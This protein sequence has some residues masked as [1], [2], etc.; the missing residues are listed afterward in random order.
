[1]AAIAARRRF[2]RRAAT[3]PPAGARAA[4]ALAALAWIAASVY[5][6]SP[7]SSRASRIGELWGSG[8]NR[9]CGTGADGNTDRSY[10]CVGGQLGVG[11]TV[12]RADFAAAQWPASAG[13]LPVVTARVS[14]GQLHTLILRDDGT[15]HATG[16]NRYGQLGLGHT[17]M[18]TV[19]EPMPIGAVTTVEAGFGYSIML[20]S[21]GVL[22]ACG[23]NDLHQL[24]LG[25]DNDRAAPTQIDV[26]P[27]MGLSSPMVTVSAGEN[28]V[29]AVN[30]VGEVFAW[31]S[32]ANG[33]LGLGDRLSSERPAPVGVAA[34]LN[35]LGM[36]LVGADGKVQTVAAGRH[37]SVIIYRSGAASAC[38]LNGHGQLGMNGLSAR[39]TFE[40]CQV[41]TTVAKVALGQMHTLFLLSDGSVRACGG[42][43]EGQLGFES[44]GSVMVPLAVNTLQHVVQIAAAGDFSLAVLEDGS[45]WAMGDNNKGQLGVL[46]VSSGYM[47][48]RVGKVGYGVSDVATGFDFVHVIKGACHADG[49][50]PSRADD[51]W[52]HGSLC[53][54]SPCLPGRYAGAASQTGRTQCRPGSVGDLADC[55]P[56]SIGRYTDIDGSIAESDCLACAAGKYSTAEGSGLCIDCESGRYTKATRNTVGCDQCAMGRYTQTVGAATFDECV[57]C[58]VGSIAAVGNSTCDLCQAGLFGA[59]AD[60]LSVDLRCSL[61]D[62]GDYS[63]G[64]QFPN[65]HPT[66]TTQEAT[67]SECE[68]DSEWVGTFQITNT[69]YPAGCQNDTCASHPVVFSEQVI[70]ADMNT[71]T[72][73]LD[74]FT[75]P[76][77]AF[78]GSGLPPLSPICERITRTALSGRGVL[79]SGNLTHTQTLQQHCNGVTGTSAA[80]NGAATFAVG[81][82]PVACG[83]SSGCGRS[84]SGGTILRDLWCDTVRLTFQSEVLFCSP[85]NWICPLN[86]N[87]YCDTNALSSIE[88]K[89]RS[90]SGAV[91][92]RVDLIDNQG[93]QT[94]RSP[95]TFAVPGGQ[96]WVTHSL[97]F[98]QK[99]ETLYREGVD[100][101]RITGLILYILDGSTYTSFQ[102]EMSV[103]SVHSANGSPLHETAV[104][105]QGWGLHPGVDR[106]VP[107]TGCLPCSIG[108]YLDTR[109]AVGDLGNCLPCRTGMFSNP[110]SAQCAP[111]PT[112]TYLVGLACVDCSPG[113]YSGVLGAIHSYVCSPCAVGRYTTSSGTSACTHCALGKYSERSGSMTSSDC[114]N[115]P[116]GKH[117]NSTEQGDYT[118][119]N[120]CPGGRVSL[121]GAAVCELCPVGKGLPS[122][123]HFGDLNLDCDSCDPGKYSTVETQRFAATWN[124]EMGLLEQAPN[125]EFRVCSDCPAGRWHDATGASH[126]IACDGGRFSSDPG[127]T[128]HLACRECDLGKVSGMGDE[129]CAGCQHGKTFI[130]I[131]QECTGCPVGTDSAFESECSACDRPKLCLGNGTCEDGYKGR[132]CTNCDDGHFQYHK[133]CY[134]CPPNSFITLAFG[135]GLFLLF[136][137]VMI[138]LG[139][140]SGN[141]AMGGVVAPAALGVA[142]LQVSLKVFEIDFNLPDFVLDV[143]KWL[144]NLIT[145]DF[146]G[147]ATPECQWPISDP[148]LL[149]LFRV[150]E[151]TALLPLTCVTILVLSLTWVM[152]VNFDNDRP[153]P[154][155]SIVT[156]FSL[157]Y[158]AMIS[159][160]LHTLNCGDITGSGELRLED[161]PDVRCQGP[162]DEVVQDLHRAQVY[163]MVGEGFCLS[164]RTVG[165]F[166]THLLEASD[167]DSLQVLVYVE[168]NGRVRDGL[169]TESIC[170]DSCTAHMNCA[171][172]SYTD[173][174]AAPADREAAGRCFL[175]GPYLD[176]DL[177]PWNS[178]ETATDEWRAY[179]KGKPN[180]KVVIE[181]TTVAACDDTIIRGCCQVSDGMQ[182]SGNCQQMCCEPLEADDGEQWSLILAQKAGEKEEDGVRACPDGRSVHGLSHGTSHDDCRA[183]STVCKTK[184]TH[185]SYYWIIASLGV[186]ILVVCGIVL[187]VLIFQKLRRADRQNQFVMKRYGWLYHRFEER[188]WFYEF[189]VMGQKAVIIAIATFLGRPDKAW[190]A[191]GAMLGCIFLMLAM[192][193]RVQPWVEREDDPT[194]K[195]CCGKCLSTRLTL[196]RLEEAGICCQLLTVIPCGY[197]IGVD[198]TTSST[199]I[200]LGVWILASQGMFVLAVI[201]VQY[202]KIKQKDSL[203]HKYMARTMNKIDGRPETEQYRQTRELEAEAVQ[204][205]VTTD[206]PAHVDQPVNPYLDLHDID[207]SHTPVGRPKPSRRSRIVAA[208]EG[209]HEDQTPHPESSTRQFS[210]P[211]RAPLVDTVEIRDARGRTRYIEPPQGW[212]DWDDQTKALYQNLQVLI[213]GKVDELD[214]ARAYGRSTEHLESELA[215]LMTITEQLSDGSLQRVSPQDQE[216]H[217][218]GAGEDEGMT[219]D[220]E[221]HNATDGGMMDSRFAPGFTDGTAERSG[222][223]GMAVRPRIV[224]DAVEDDGDE[225]RRGGAYRSPPSS[226]L[227]LVSV[228]LDPADLM[229]MSD[230]WVGDDDIRAIAAVAGD[231]SDSDDSYE[232]RAE[233]RRRLSAARTE[234]ASDSD[235]GDDAVE[236]STDEEQDERD[237]Q[238]AF[239]IAQRR[240]A[241]TFEAERPRKEEAE[242][243]DDA[244]AFEGSQEQGSDEDWLGSDEDMI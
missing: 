186:S 48:M 54:C 185:E 209:N 181:T 56:C 173:L 205:I 219:D 210:V 218:D 106:V 187:P 102:G 62:F 207:R 110:G 111:C 25:D 42:N 213:D 237:I 128:T 180:A 4:A 44:A 191:W 58:P 196:N 168:V 38:G 43:Q 105:G 114:V 88:I 157:M 227:R 32:N 53:A 222:V 99:F 129:G 174:V 125:I 20:Q 148:E 35:D 243:S 220:P 52:N 138:R 150:S 232:D 178:R 223:V 117:K 201:L 68:D 12:N 164:T 136:A 188:A 165:R 46:G 40:P 163:D 130:A 208:S 36:D 50:F 51:I 224:L 30:A 76:C 141:Q 171:A 135:V 167:S 1:M 231:S 132:W 198:D 112:G 7:A 79:G 137:L 179:T 16:N 156:A 21:D 176:A 144:S 23:Q 158:V 13:V 97:D 145:L 159:T 107:E 27:V 161:K 66:G 121:D 162:W 149:Y 199:A 234:A 177:N 212:V 216:P 84:A 60:V 11:D 87:C 113:Q 238:A 134:E 172:Y 10:A 189:V 75:G 235:S 153:N 28:H 127:R 192:Q 80:Q 26:P 2:S 100:A 228:D 229:V 175:H 233:L 94:S 169:L 230:D 74:V 82:C 195:L 33:A 17:L 122:Y 89:I 24:G 146:V 92:V 41:P 184:R 63:T 67:F 22:W 203:L 90:L 64:S 108:K 78:Q 204:G 18:V 29:L 200:V 190:T 101:R 59:S 6:Q 124:G 39:R 98:I 120:S 69:I 131:D 152:A 155:N 91:N 133:H 214:E 55:A 45:L 211:G 154:I 151:M 239:R 96:E 118:S 109:G 123:E 70:C 73:C 116:G 72:C 226:P 126:C 160:G 86:D 61:D 217:D 170:Q 3:M 215:R 57:S 19:P 93:K 140:V 14:G 240:V 115:C 9:F 71:L 77:V 197:F 225:P 15:V 5:A 85:N 182:A 194:V 119:C 244:A 202:T 103:A 147:F 183:P 236:A 95:L 83:R 31:G 34:P 139:K 242:S 65:F 241:P 104:W 166:N 221:G 142:R 37:H 47:P 206:N 49:L 193:L 143:L 81:S 8:Q